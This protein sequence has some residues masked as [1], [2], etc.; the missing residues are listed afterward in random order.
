MRLYWSFFINCIEIQQTKLLKTS[1]KILKRITA[2]FKFAIWKKKKDWGNDVRMVLV[3]M[4][5]EVLL[6]AENESGV[7][8]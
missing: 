2:V 7:V 5:I 8:F 4:V 3:L 1:I 6:V